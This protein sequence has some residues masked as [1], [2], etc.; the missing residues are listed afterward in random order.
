MR[1]RISHVAS[2]LLA[3]AAALAL[4]WPVDAGWTGAKSQHLQGQRYIKTTVVE[5]PATYKVARF[6]YRKPTRI[7][8]YST[9]GCEAK[10]IAWKNGK[11]RVRGWTAADGW[12]RIPRAVRYPN[13]VVTRVR[14]VDSTEEQVAL[15]QPPTTNGKPVQSN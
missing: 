1:V 13:K 3:G 11:R 15:A 7:N 8:V 12:W 14:C 2:A 5:W 4:V 10:V 9:A 6:R